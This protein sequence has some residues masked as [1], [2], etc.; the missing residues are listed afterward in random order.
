M[1]PSSMLP[2][3]F[4]TLSWEQSAATNPRIGDDRGEESFWQDFAPSY[5][6]KSPLAEH[7]A[8]LL[9][10][11][12]P[13]LSNDDELIEVGPGTGAFT[14]RLAPHVRRVIG[15]EPSESMR[16]VLI[17][18]WTGSKEPE[19]VA[20]KWE[21]CL[22]LRAETLF[23]ANAFYRIRDMR[24]CLRQMHSAARRHI[25]LVQTIGNPYAAPLSVSVDG[26]PIQRERADAI[27]D[28]LGELGIA[29]RRR[30]YTIDRGI[31]PIHDVAL[32]DWSPAP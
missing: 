3:E 7:A 16:K 5:D 27:G 29:F 20:A 14:K 22:H 19:L 13:L 12:Y 2:S 24:A 17:A 30:T 25:I 26:T 32:L 8:I 18:G 9:A 4:W 21:E 15:V 31:G 10:D 6:E 23:S 11:V 28:I 1:Q